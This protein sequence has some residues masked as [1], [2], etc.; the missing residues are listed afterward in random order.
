MPTERSYPMTHARTLAI[1]V[2]IVGS[3]HGLGG[4]GVSGYRK[5]ELG[6]NVASVSSLSGLTSSDA[7][8]IHERPAVL[9]DL[10]WRPS[11]WT[12]GT[13]ADLTVSTDPVE[14]VLFSFYND[15]LFRVV[16]DYRRERTEGMTTADMIEATSAVYGMPLART[17]RVA[18]VASR[19]EVES[20]S[21][22]AR[23]G[24]S[25]HSVVLY[26]T[27]SYGAVFRL[28]VIDV[29]LDNLAQKAATQAQRLDDRESPQR[30]AAR[31]QK[32]RDESRVAA[33]KARAENKNVFR[34]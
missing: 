18:G 3:T 14:Q 17:A 22:V 34:P 5:F 27:S 28:V 9:Q 16:V 15:Q 4:E 13:T 23:W 11:H 29:R 24:N 31:Q 12:S 26:Q 10:E 33:A 20:G 30:D 19:F 32:E 2:A 25:E 21:P 7:K 8:T 6:S 1:C